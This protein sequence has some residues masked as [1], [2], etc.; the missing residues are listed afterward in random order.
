MVY[1]RAGYVIP[2]RDLDV[3]GGKHMGKG[4][5]REWVSI[6]PYIEA[7]KEIFNAKASIGFNGRVRQAF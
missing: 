5:R 3:V 2:R 1:T 4:A 6:D 7:I